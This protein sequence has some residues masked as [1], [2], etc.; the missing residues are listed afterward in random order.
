MMLYNSECKGGHNY[1]TETYLRS[2]GCKE[3]GR[4]VSD[5]AKL[6]PKKLYWSSGSEI[7]DAQ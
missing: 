4:P 1:C 2:I 5:C 6:F 3:N 7:M